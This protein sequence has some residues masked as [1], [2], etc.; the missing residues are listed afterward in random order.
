M[1]G[2]FQDCKLHISGVDY[3]LPSEVPEL[4][5]KGAWLVDLRT[6][7]ETEI[8]AFGV[9]RVIYLPYEELNEKF[10][11]LKPED[12]LILADSVGLHSKEALVFL[13]TKGYKHLASLAGG[14]AD[15][16]KDGLPMRKGKYQPLNG[17]CPCMIRPKEKGQ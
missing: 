10:G 1:D 16:E 7:F 2:F 5:G 11:I 6:E 3:A 13:R 14:I 8:R 17:P 12:P 4:L 9:E 15:W